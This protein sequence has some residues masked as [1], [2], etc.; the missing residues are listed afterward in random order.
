MILINFGDKFLLFFTQ[1][2]K[3]TNPSKDLVTTVA[4]IFAG[5]APAVVFPA[6]PSAVS[7]SVVDDFS[8]SRVIRQ[9][10]I[11]QFRTVNITVVVC[12]L[13]GFI[14]PVVVVDLV[15]TV[16]VSAVVVHWANSV[17]VPRGLVFGEADPVT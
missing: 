9:V 14:A 2:S 15:E 17:G 3:T 8:A 13:F 5:A 6:V 16:V 1:I 12:W 7:M 10:V 4:S 11:S